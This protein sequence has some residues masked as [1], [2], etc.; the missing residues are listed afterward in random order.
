LRGERKNK[1]KRTCLAAAAVVTAADASWQHIGQTTTPV[2][3]HI[4]ISS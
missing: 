1:N 4:Q 2:Q 3:Y